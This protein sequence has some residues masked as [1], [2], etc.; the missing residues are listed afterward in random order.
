MQ[1][2]FHTMEAIAAED[3]RGRGIANLVQ[4]GA[5]RA[6]AE[7]LQASKTVVLVSGF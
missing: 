7:S 3:P 2:P 1:D 4:W 6:A 5:L